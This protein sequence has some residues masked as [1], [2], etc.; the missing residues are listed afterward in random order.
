MK[1]KVFYPLWTLQHFHVF[2]SIH[3]WDPHCDG[4]WKWNKPTPFSLIQLTKK[5]TKGLPELHISWQKIEDGSK[6]HSYLNVPGFGIKS[7]SFMLP[8]PFLTFCWCLLA[9]K[10]LSQTLMWLF[11]SVCKTSAL[12]NYSSS[13]TTEN[14]LNNTCKSLQ[15]TIVLQNW[16]RTRKVW[17]QP[18]WAHVS[19]D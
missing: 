19:N 14:F 18:L 6:P 13:Q 12:R 2:I 15:F 8:F 10:T 1:K 9:M 7:P 3:F 5:A 16:F 11:I 17:V 4:V